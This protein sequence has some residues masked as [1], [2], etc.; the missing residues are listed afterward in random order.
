[1]TVGGRADELFNKRCLGGEMS[2]VGEKSI[3]CLV[4]HFDLSLASNL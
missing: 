3:L 1:M 2:G 4:P